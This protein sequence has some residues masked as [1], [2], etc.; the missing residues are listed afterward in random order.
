MSQRQYHID[1]APGDVADHILLVGDPDRAQ[2]VANQFDSIRYSNSHREYRLHTG[3]HE[4]LDVTVVC[5]GMGAGSM[6]IGVVEL[7]QIV[8]QPTFI[9]CG[10]CGA[11][12]PGLDLGDLVIAQGAYRLESA[13]LGFVG[14]GYPAFA[15]AEAVIA[16]CQ[17]A[18]E[19]G[20]THH[21]GVT[22]TASGFYGAQGR[23]APGFPPRDP[24]SVERLA[25]Q[26]VLNLEM[27]ASCL[28][29]LAAM[30]GAR[31]GAV[32]AVYANR[33][34][35]TFIEQPAMGEAEERCFKVGLGALHHLAAMRKARGTRPHWH[36][37]V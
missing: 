18:E 15:H 12:Q 30:R 7:C 33:P 17:A 19:S 32:C 29:T 8:E 6:E 36:P 34:Q 9:R 21:V 14:E 27:E 3:R 24:E 25:A 16:L 11:L 5:V 28:F 2:S 13:S 31:A 1:A 37:G 22:A 23:T 20:A 35:D 26:G 4:G 10:S